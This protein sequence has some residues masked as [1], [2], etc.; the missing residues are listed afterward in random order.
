MGSA[1]MI[2]RSELLESKMPAPDMSTSPTG[3][4]QAEQPR[5]SHPQAVRAFNVTPAVQTYMGGLPAKPERF[6]PIDY[7]P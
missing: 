6:K 1:E 5:Q 2:T 3:I 4:N 7:K